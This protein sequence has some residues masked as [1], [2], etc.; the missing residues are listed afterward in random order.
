MKQLF[1][2]VFLVITAGIMAQAPHSIPYQAVV[3]NTDGSVM[4]GA[5][6]NITFKIHDNSATGT[7]VYE[8]THSTTA[9]T[10]GLVSLNVGSG[11]ALY[12][13][14][15]N[16]NWGVGNKFLHVLMNSGNGYVDL[17]T[18]QMMSVPYALFAK[19]LN[20]RVSSIG[21]SLILGNSAI[22]IP[23]ISLANLTYTSNSG[24]GA[25]K[26]PQN[27]SCANEII[28]ISGCGDLNSLD[29]LGYNYGLVEIGG[30]CWFSENLRST[31]FNNGS[32]I[33]LI[34]NNTNWASTT[35][36]AYCYYN[37]D[38]ANIQSFGMLYNGFTVTSG[39]ICPTGWHVPTDCDWK[40]LENFLGLTVNEQNNL[41]YRG[42]NSIGGVL[43]STS[44]LWA[45]PNFNATNT[46]GFNGLP[47]GVRGNG[48]INLNTYG[49]WWSSTNYVFRSLNS[50]GANIYRDVSSGP[51]GKS[52]RC[53]RD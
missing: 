27:S 50:D 4:A 25:E 26:F 34:T 11:V 2:L 16:I 49:Y 31:T 32:P 44:P 35:T 10:Q 46:T 43:K 28:S 36:P 52:I 7:V 41:G 22:I 5:N 38:P 13:S 53:L 42:G 29:Y 45:S 37:N 23:G 1:T 14:F 19:D 17:G 6:M 51:I 20:V 24:L 39:N 8:E 33:P 40:Y 18:Q 12:G 21:D 30:Q 15:S 48:S 47:G 3:R 9:N